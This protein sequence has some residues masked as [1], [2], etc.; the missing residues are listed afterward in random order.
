MDG[1][2]RWLLYGDSVDGLDRSDVSSTSAAAGRRDPRRGPAS[3]R[4]PVH[5]EGLLP[6]RRAN[7]RA[8]VH[9]TLGVKHPRAMDL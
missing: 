8:G 5:S 7:E 3:R 6:R 4:S 1:R 9:L 2:K